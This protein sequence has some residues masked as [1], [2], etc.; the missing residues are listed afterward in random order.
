MKIVHTA[1]WHIG[2][3]LHKHPLREELLL[4]LDWLLDLITREEID[5]LLV[6]GD[7]FDLANP[8]TVDTKD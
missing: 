1:D 6:S 3:V 5:V 2:K 8:N 7:I 4:F